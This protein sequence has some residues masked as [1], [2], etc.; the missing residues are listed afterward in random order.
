MNHSTGSQTLLHNAYTNF[1][2]FRL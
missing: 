2:N 1:E